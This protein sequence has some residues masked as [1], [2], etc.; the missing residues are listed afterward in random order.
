MKHGGL[1]E[2]CETVR[3]KAK[4]NAS[5][6][7]RLA[8]ETAKVILKSGKSA[9]ISIIT[10]VVRAS[11]VNDGI[12]YRRRAQDGPSPFH[13]LAPSEEEAL[14]GTYLLTHLLRPA[15]THECALLCWMQHAGVLDTAVS[16][17]PQTETGGIA[18]CKLVPSQ[19]SKSSGTY[20]AADSITEE[21]DQGEE[22]E[23][24]EKIRI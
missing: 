11:I 21:C 1:R 8:W 20:T 22:E 5:A 4:T 23:I 2:A 7:L 15:N 14:R 18:S 24:Q 19:Q 6:P 13:C 3:F 17:S 12:P 10:S 9:S 16:L